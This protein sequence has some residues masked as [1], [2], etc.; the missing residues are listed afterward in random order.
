MQT[1]KQPPKQLP[2]Q[3][4]KQQPKEQPKSALGAWF[5]FFSFAKVKM[6]DNDNNN[7]DNKTTYTISRDDELVAKATRCLKIRNALVFYIP[8]LN[9]TLWSK[10]VNYIYFSFSGD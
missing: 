2:K 7:N 5:A 1:S 9:G 3:Q 8:I 10:Y 4:S 6:G